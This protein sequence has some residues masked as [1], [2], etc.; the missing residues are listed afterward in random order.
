VLGD[1]PGAGGGFRDGGHLL[2]IGFAHS[3]LSLDRLTSEIDL[4]PV[5]PARA[6]GWLIF[7]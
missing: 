4:G 7:I 2:G 5:Y 6:L 3:L 1:Q